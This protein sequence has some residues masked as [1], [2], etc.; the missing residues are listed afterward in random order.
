MTQVDSRLSTGLPGMDRILRGL[1]PGDNIVW[2]VDS[3]DDFLPFVKPYCRW[4]VENGRRLIYFRFA[5]HAPLVEPAPGVEI[6]TLRAEDGF[7]QFISQIH[8]A[9]R[10]AGKGAYYLFDCLS[11]LAADWYSDQMLGNFFML[12]CPYLFDLETVTYFPLLRNYHSFYATTPISE[13]T[14]LWLDVLRHEGRLYLRPI[15]VQQRYSPTMH[16]LHVWEGATFEPVRQSA[17]IA[18]ISRSSS[19]RGPGTWQY[20]LDVWNRAFLEAEETLAA[21]RYGEAPPERL[22][23]HRRRLLRMAVCRQGRMLELGEKYFTLSDLLEIGRRMIGSGLIGG[24]SVGMLL[25]RAILKQSD[26][27][28]EGVL[29]SHD[30]FFIG[31]NVFYTF[32]VTNGLWWVRRL[33]QDPAA[34]LEGAQ[35][36]RHGIL[37]GTFPDHIES[38]IADMLDYFGQSPIIVRSSSLLE[39]D[40]GNAFAGK[41]ESVFCV[42]QGSREKRLA[43]FLSAVRSIYASTMSEKALSYRAHRGL[44][45]HDE[46]MALLIQRVSGAVHGNFYYPHMAGVALSFNP[47]VWNRQIDPNSGVLRLV[48][49][50]GTRAVDRH[51]DDYTRVVALNAPDKRPEADFKEARQYSQKRVDV[52]DLEANQL[53]SRRFDD[54]VR[55]SHDLPVDMFSSSEEPAGDAA[56]ALTFSG[57]LQRTRFVDDM[58]DMLQT[59]Q[60]AY[61]YP[62]DV[63]FTANFLDQEHYR[64]DLVQCRPFQYKGGGTVTRLPEH[65]TPRDLV[66]T[67][68]GAVIGQS[69]DIEVGRLIYVVP[70]AYGEL[71]ISDR[72]NI[73]RLIGRIAHACQGGPS[74][75]NTMLL[76][77][78]R[79]GTTTP[80]LGVPIRFSDISSVSILCEIVTMR[81]GV[82]PEVSLGTH[83]FNEMVEM[84]MLYLALFPTSEGNS[85]NSEVFNIR[86]DRLAALVP[87]AEKWNE[88]VRVIHPED[89]GPDVHI[90]LNANTIDQE[91]VCYLERSPR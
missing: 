80:S 8:N 60:I 75:E 12:T 82:V 35:A 1:I 27:R 17:M 25:S 22:D 40:F 91:V 71:T 77:P 29:E 59:I 41:Y 46:Q 45:G 42:N 21:V 47:Y 55:Q 23:D 43:D 44:L 39:D 89:I 14:Q 37:V 86:T 10:D 34:L 56:G 64:I 6:H 19:W 33:N 26:R 38:Q 20:R 73:A 58:R 2:Q 53:E 83:L 32:L 62:V 18:D 5:D 3:I 70:E 87:G 79:W 16:M 7:E 28:W 72:H 30:S 69:R 9:I 49:G 76:G 13:T 78:G 24:K 65:L 67:A 11:D 88:V 31:A 57:L 51:D 4:A 48:F 52:L 15:K 36:A 50:L 61:D 74:P 84:D 90:R 68:R 66:L 81:E 54:V 85:I 63:E